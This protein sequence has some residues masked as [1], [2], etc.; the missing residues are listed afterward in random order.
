MESLDQLASGLGQALTPEY[1]LFALIG[2]VLGQ[3]VGVLPGVGPTAGIA[4]LI[5]LTFD[6][7]PTGAIIMLAAIYYG[8]MYGGTITSVLLNTPGEAASVVT[9]LDGYQMAR[10]GR[11]GV[12]LGISAIG[13]FIGAT[14]ATFGLVL[15]A[16][17]LARFALRF[18]PAEQ[19]ALLVLGLSTLIGLTGRSVV[20]G[21]I[22]GILGLMLGLIGLDPVVGAPRLT[23]GMV[24]LFDGI[25]FVTVA[26]GLFGISEI[27]L[28][29]EQP[30]MKI[31]ETKVANLFPK[32]EEW[33]RAGGAIL[34]GTG[35]GFVLG[36]VPGTNSAIA[37][38]LAYVVER[39]FTKQP[40][41]TGAIEGVAAP[42]TANNAYTSAALIPLFTLGIPSS[43][44][45]AV[46]MGAFI[47]NG[48]VPGPLLFR[49]NPTF[50]WTVI[51]SLYVGNAILLLLNLPLVGLWVQVLKIPYPIL[52]VLIL[53][54][55][56]VGSYS[57]NGSMF[58]V[59]TMFLFGVLGYFFKK[60]DLPMAPMILALVLGPLI[61]RSLRTSLEIS[62]GELSIFYT[63]PIAVTLLGIAAIVLVSSALPILSLRRARAAASED[64]EI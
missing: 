54:F 56:I 34:R 40:L 53:V 22:M 15:V 60:L 36:L 30:A 51:A 13:S 18:G 20:L 64:A 29:L 23:F 9:T 45:I 21:L 55:S 28:N 35:L 27:L 6:L 10:Q 42:E 2:C 58:D 59:G 4:V 37:S 12:A 14:I 63:S 52:M 11:G 3:L 32:R 33:R 48:L 61:E 44:A 17:P 62:G 25:E 5:P 31:F 26:M 50:V 49:D 16:P 43:P 41:G 47:I 24:Q 1:L 8:A 46:L 19:F 7:D 39:R 38:F 57:L